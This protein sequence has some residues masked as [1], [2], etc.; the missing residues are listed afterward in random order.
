[1]SL[2]MSL[3]AKPNIFFFSCR[4]DCYRLEL[5][6]PILT[7]QEL[8]SVI[9]IKNSTKGK[10]KASV[11]D[12]LFKNSDSGNEL[13]DAIDR[14]CYEAKSHIKDGSNINSV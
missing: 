10:L 12:I 4:N 3:G 11:I 2:K 5:E 13:Q 9:D 14:I 6:E 1:M 7:N 8:E